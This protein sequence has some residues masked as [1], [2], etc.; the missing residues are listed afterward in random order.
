MT[1][2]RGPA[3]VRTVAVVLDCCFSDR[4]R[5]PSR[6]L[7]SNAI[8]EQAPVH[9]GFLLTSA[10]RDELALAAAGERHTRFTGTLIGLL[11]DGDPAGPRELTLDHLYRFL[12]RELRDGGGPRPHRHSSDG[13]GELVLALNPAYHSRPTASGDWLPG[14]PLP[15]EDATDASAPGTGN[16]PCP[17]RGLR[18]F[19]PEDARYFFG[20]DDLVQEVT[21]RAE[22]ADGL[23]A[24]IGPS[25]C[26]KTSLLRAG[27]IPWLLEQGRRVAIMVPGGDPLASLVARED[28]LSGSGGLLVIDQFEELFSAEVTEDSR[29]CFLDRLARLPAVVIALR[30]DFYGQ[31]LRYPELVR[32]LRENQVIVGPMSEDGPSGKKR[33]AVPGGEPGPSARRAARG[34]A[35]AAAPP[36]CPVRHLRAGPGGRDRQRDLGAAARRRSAACGR[37]PVLRPRRG[38]RGIALHRSWPGRAALGGCLPGL[39]HR[40]RSYPAVHIREPAG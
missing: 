34:P 14:D 28:A 24:L 23:L 9:G 30:A 15:G 26:G 13:A 4:G 18:P 33:P 19:G 17:F 29:C 1:D 22:S 2:E 21:Q 36:R 11:R 25:G 38:R 27:A 7:P 10:A 37:D 16:A 20:R 5:V 35:P 39:P 12:A 6:Q 3:K 8:F 40:V 32:A 31:C